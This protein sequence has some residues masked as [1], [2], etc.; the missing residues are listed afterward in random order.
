[1]KTTLLQKLSLKVKAKNQ[2]IKIR[3]S[4]LLKKECL[5]EMP[6]LRNKIRPKSNHKVEIKRANKIKRSNK[7][8][9]NRKKTRNNKVV[10]RRIK[11]NKEIKDKIRPR[12]NQESKVEIRNNKADKVETKKTRS[13]KVIKVATKRIRNN[14]EEKPKIRK[15]RNKNKLVEIKAVKI[16]EKV[17]VR[18]TR[19][20]VTIPMVITGASLRLPSSLLLQQ[21]LRHPFFLS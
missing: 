12:S 8:E 4:H 3:K 20:R 1:M 9:L 7:M 11:S 18:K 2:A 13:H 6:P 14:K 10:T 21:K 16:K 17:T 15:K 19:L 5:Q